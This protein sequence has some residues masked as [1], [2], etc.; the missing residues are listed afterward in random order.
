MNRFILIIQP[1]SLDTEE[2]SL[3]FSNWG[4]S[5]NQAVS[6]NFTGD[7]LRISLFNILV[8]ENSLL[9]TYWPRQ[10]SPLKKDFKEL[11]YYLHIL[12][13]NIQIHPPIQ[14]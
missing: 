13:K 12:Q 10:S 5:V 6:L 3:I 4:D 1:N 14:T 7:K 11:T 2:L 8:I 9:G